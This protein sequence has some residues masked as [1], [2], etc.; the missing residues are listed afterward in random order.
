MSGGHYYEGAFYGLVME[1]L[2]R[3][4]HE[5]MARQIAPG[6]RVLDAG[7]GAGGLALR[8][9]AQAREVVGVDH[10]PA[11]VAYAERRRARAA[12]ANVSF[13]AGDAASAL[14][15]RPDGDFD[16]ATLVLALH[17]MPAAVRGPVLRELCR[18]A[19]RVVCLDFRV[20]MPRNF[21]GLRNRFFEV[22]AG[23]QHFRAFRDFTG[24]GGVPGIAEAAGL[25][26]EHQR[27][28]DAGS[29]TLVTLTRGA[30]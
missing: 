4:L 16:V 26:W 13:V 11:M 23:R 25:R 29:L 24:R 21:A 12:V 5:L 17:E 3:G 1:P 18:L 19:T 9:A 22:A 6:E 30:A 7:S 2:Q 20:P 15:A 14:A 28:V 10:A 27:D 8:M